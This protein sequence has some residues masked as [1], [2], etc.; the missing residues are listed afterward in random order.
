MGSYPYPRN[1]VV[2]LDYEFILI[3]KKDGNPE[4][5]NT[6]IK[7]KSK[8]T[9]EEWNTYFSGHWNF[10]GEKQVRH[11]AA[12]PVELP[13]RLIKMYSF[14]DEIILDPFLGSGT[15]SVAAMN[16]NRNSIGYEI[17]NAYLPLIQQKLEKHK[18]DNRINTDIRYGRKHLSSI[19][20]SKAIKKLP[21]VFE[22]R[23]Q[24]NPL[25]YE[26][27]KNITGK[28]NLIQKNDMQY[29]SV[30]KV[31]TADMIFLDNNKK[32]RLL[33][34]R[35]NP[36][37]KK[38]AIRYLE[39]KIL[40]QKVTIKYEHQQKDEDDILTGYL[41]LKNKTFINA[42]LIKEGLVLNDN[43]VDHKYREK[44]GRYEKEARDLHSD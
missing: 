42:K 26:A 9:A 44:F 20:L 6:E 34:I 17:N 12:F 10:P 33:G 19:D 8:L 18:T 14:V 1:G 38:E 25:K 29:F 30:K 27:K 41:Y 28:R 13:S 23:N 4:P 22:D 37:K 35:I 3:F 5:V 36:A 31:I 40:S 7:K 21:Y 32:L 2:K 16:L 11:Q 39:D 24:P 15:T 43:A